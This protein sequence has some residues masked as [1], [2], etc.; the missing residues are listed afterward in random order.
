MS[1]R[2]QIIDRAR[3]ATDPQYY[4]RLRELQLIQAGYD[5]KQLKSLRSAGTYQDYEI[6][7]YE[8]VQLNTPDDGVSAKIAQDSKINAMS[9][10]LSKPELTF[11]NVDQGFT[12]VNSAWFDRAWWEL[13]FPSK[14]LEIDSDMSLGLSCAVVG[15]DEEGKPNWKR[16]SALKVLYDPMMRL[17]SDWRYC[18]TI[19]D[20]DV[21][22]VCATFN[23]KRED[24]EPLAK[25]RTVVGMNGNNPSYSPMVVRVYRYYS[26]E[27]DPKLKI[28]TG[29]H[30]VIVGPMYAS[31]A[32]WLTLDMSGEGGFLTYRKM[33]E[34]ASPNPYP[35][36]PIE[37]CWEM[38]VSGVLRPVGRAHWESAIGI[39][40][41]RIMKSVSKDIEFGGTLRILSSMGI[42]EQT[43]QR[44]RDNGSF[45]EG[46]DRMLVMELAQSVKDAIDEKPAI[47]IPGDRLT[48]LQ[49]LVGELNEASGVSDAQRGQANQGEMTAF[50]FAGR[51]DAQGVQA[52]HA[53]ERRSQFI[54]G[55]VYKL[56]KCAA[57]YE[58][59]QYTLQLPDGIEVD[60]KVFSLKPFLSKE[61]R[62]GVTEDSMANL[63]QH[64]RAILA[65]E[66]FRSVDMMAI[67][68]GTLD[69]L[70]A[71]ENIVKDVYG[72]IDPTMRGV[73]TREQWDA[74]QQQQMMQSL[75]AQMGQSGGMPT[76]QPE[77][78]DSAE[79]ATEGQ[80]E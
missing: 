13:D 60:T 22:Q 44:I 39:F 7:A 17:P 25:R 64:Q 69:P 40:I 70:T 2:Q 37:A 38:F 8:D 58:D 28:K 49:F 78:E 76:Q 55:L 66:R 73:L 30:V 53:K 3:T 6:P 34:N 56:R 26:Y 18:F 19:D 68:L 48:W 29:K 20:Y 41:Q 16:Y 52:R 35:F 27:W 46:S 57:M 1:D 12:S 62:I 14:L 80:E 45:D 77:K 33:K 32:I 65:I 15:I 51:Q 67:Q 59:R 36:L 21:D 9:L 31:N 24:V 47:P 11:E 74:K 63:G 75:M 79:N 42:D 23:L 43:L 5:H 50:E 10:S 72:S 4:Q 71:T 54:S 61:V